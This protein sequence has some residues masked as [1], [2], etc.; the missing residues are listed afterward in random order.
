M[1]TTAS[2]ALIEQT[3]APGSTP[4]K[5]L[6]EYESL[7]DNGENSTVQEIQFYWQL[8]RAE[9]KDDFERRVVE[10]INKLGF[11]D[12]Y[13]GLVATRMGV[14]GNIASSRNDLFEIYVKEEFYCHDMILQHC[15]FSENPIFMS[16][17]E[18]YIS[19][20][21]FQTEQFKLTGEIINFY[22]KHH[23]YDIYNIPF[24]SQTGSG[25]AIF[26]VTKKHC[27][28]PE[29]RQLVSNS[30]SVLHLLAEAIDYI[31]GTKFPGY[32]GPLKSREPAV[33]TPKPLRLLETLAKKNMTLKKAAEQLC[34]SLDT[35]NKH[36]ASAKKALGAST[37]ASAVYMALKKGLISCD[38][39]DN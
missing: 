13:Y 20:A 6:V 24:K 38:I 16:T 17:V 8:A 33:I 39:E 25:N 12:F 36:I 1:N 14:N 29:F 19:S 32:F 15:E 26:S 31:G 2:K 4:E 34:I 18:S 21:P 22:K 9:D 37:Q 5:Q 10:V 11:S 28:Q 3:S 23:Y 7:D 27:A 30:K 35:A